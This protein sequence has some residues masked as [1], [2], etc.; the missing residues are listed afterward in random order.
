MEFPSSGVYIV[1][2]KVIGIYWRR[3]D[4]L[5]IEVSSISRPLLMI[6]P[7]TSMLGVVT[8]AAV[9]IMLR[10]YKITVYGLTLEDF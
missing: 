10:R 1:E 4:N 6:G 2:A 5:D 8:L 9:L 7:V 3:F